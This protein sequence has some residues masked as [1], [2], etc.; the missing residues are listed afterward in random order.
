MLLSDA[1][2][3][4]QTTSEPNI[5]DPVQCLIVPV[6]VGARS[7]IGQVLQGEFEEIEQFVDLED[8]VI[9]RGGAMSTWHIVSPTPLG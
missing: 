3:W 4:R 9:V 1:S 6:E 2:L 5:D 7:G 8:E